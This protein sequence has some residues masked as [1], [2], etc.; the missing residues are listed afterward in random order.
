LS[1]AV[2]LPNFVNM[3]LGTHSFSEQVYSS[4]DTLK[5]V[6]ISSNEINQILQLSH[7]VNSHPSLS[8]PQ[9]PWLKTGLKVQA[10]LYRL[11]SRSFNTM[12]PRL[13]PI[14]P[15][16]SKKCFVYLTGLYHQS[17]TVYYAEI[18]KDKLLSRTINMH[19][20]GTEDVYLH[21]SIP[22]RVRHYVN[23]S[24]KDSTFTTLDFF[25]E[26][27]LCMG[28]CTW[29]VYL[30]FETHPH[31]QDRIKQLL[32]I[33]RFLQKGATAQAALLQSH[34]WVSDLSQYILG[35]KT[36]RPQ[37]ARNGIGPGYVTCEMLHNDPSQVEQM[38]HNIAPGVYFVDCAELHMITYFKFHKNCGCVFDP[39][40]GLI[41]LAANEQAQDLVRLL[42]RYAN[43]L[44]SQKLSYVD[45]VEVQKEDPQQRANERY[46]V[47]VEVT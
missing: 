40:I 3:H 2:I 5:S 30:Y 4:Y 45:F 20:I 21:S 38:I 39:T 31:F 28:M 41:L 9:S 34:N 32:A 6:L 24:C 19:Q 18:F 42:C 35:L 23:N 17:L 11:M 25:K 7:D 13:T 36:T 15:N 1:Q 22:I 44:D 12:L 26:E 33:C 16:M 37:S 14:F 46:T 47:H 29:L 8:I 27:G 10:Y 43:A